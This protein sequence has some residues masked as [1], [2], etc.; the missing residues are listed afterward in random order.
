MFLACFKVKKREVRWT[1][2]EMR[3][4]DERSANVRR[5]FVALLEEDI[6]RWAMDGAVGSS[7]GI[8]D[9]DWNHI[10]G[11]EHREAEIRHTRSLHV[12]GT[13]W[14]GSLIAFLRQL[15]MAHGRKL[16][17]YFSSYDQYPWQICIGDRDFRWDFTSYCWHKWC[18]PTSNPRPTLLFW[19]VCL[20]ASCI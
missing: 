3:K 5:G 15:L 2:C 13:Q 12:T 4:N 18:R 9:Q 14:E 20:M 11:D 8:F 10:S 19:G 1:C 6:G 16:G 17:P 7:C